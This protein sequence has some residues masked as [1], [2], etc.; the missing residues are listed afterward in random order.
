MLA[1]VVEGV[2]AVGVPAPPVAVVYHNKFDPPAVN[3]EGASYWQYPTGVVTVGAVGAAKTVN[4]TS[5][6]SDTHEL[7]EGLSSR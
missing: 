6:R 5:V 1:V 4:V 2:G 7:P 3:V